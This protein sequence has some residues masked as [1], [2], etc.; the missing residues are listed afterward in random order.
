V[1]ANVSERGFAV[2]FSD[3]SLWTMPKREVISVIPE[4]WK[5]VRI[6]DVVRQAGDRVKVEAERPY[7]MTGVKWY[8][9]GVFARETVLGKEM[10]ANYVT[11][12]IP[13]ALIYNR[14]FAWK[15]SFAVVPEDFGEQ[16]VS[17]E[18][19]QFVVDSDR[20]L[21][22]YLYLYCMTSKV[23]D[24]VNRASAGSAAV[25]RNRLKEAA[26]LDIDFLLP[27]LAVQR[28]IVQKWR[29]ARAV[30][31]EALAFAE[32]I[33]KDAAQEFLHGLG[34]VAPG[35]AKPRKAF[36]LRWDKM[37]RWGVAVNQPT[38]GLDVADSRYPVRTL[39]ELIAYLENGWS[40]K[41]FDRPACADEWGV[42]KVGA[43][44][45]GIFDENQN[46][47]LPPSLKPIPRYEVKPGDLL[48]SRANIARLVGACALVKK[49]RP[50]LMLCDKIFRVIW[51]P[52]SELMPEYL[53][54]VLKIPHLRNQIENAL[55]GTSPTMKNIS[56][57][58]LLALR[59]PV[60][61]PEVQQTLVKAIGEA[62]Q[63]A[64]AAREKAETLKTRAAAEI[65]AAI[66]GGEAP[67]ADRLDAA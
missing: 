38:A 31:E 4:G 45:F 48:I 65:E 46:K 35:E 9:E 27:P 1:R 55:T 22:E 50:K 25:S 19:P 28:I 51:R 2:R 59:M 21:P 26:F 53:D 66:L 60:P 37:N 64:A 15:G 57:P 29:D 18:F 10:S 40:P 20:V 67:G 63:K 43:V 54:E 12:L 16:Y 41:C 6:G 7:N 39:G 44:S 47:T 5:R 42:L 52:E 23:M 36:A 56:K 33:E 58:S 17:N 62:R 49:T 34:L 24:A 32:R 14:L 3:L 61:P 30:A 11:P 8:G 13:G